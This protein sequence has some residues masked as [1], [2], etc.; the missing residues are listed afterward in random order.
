MHIDLFTDESKIYFS[1]TSESERFL[2]Q[3]NLNLFLQ[4]ANK[5]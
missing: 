4:W 1:Y 5:W 2:L 3:N